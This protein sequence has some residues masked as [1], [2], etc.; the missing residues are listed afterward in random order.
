M[1]ILYEI[2]FNKRNGAVESSALPY[3]P[4][5]MLEELMMRLDLQ[6]TQVSYLNLTDSLSDTV[7]DDWWGKVFDL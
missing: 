6:V 7:V 5:D 3:V 2:Q 4:M 1:K